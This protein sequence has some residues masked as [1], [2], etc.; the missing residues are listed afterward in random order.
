MTAKELIE[1]L[2]TINPNTLIVGYYRGY[3]DCLYG[4][5]SQYQQY[6]LDVTTGDVWEGFLQFRQAQQGSLSDKEI[7]DY[8]CANMKAT[9]GLLLDLNYSAHKD[10]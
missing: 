9:A 1:Q 8:W 4:K 10:K 3:G 2:K 7:K 5:P 6:W